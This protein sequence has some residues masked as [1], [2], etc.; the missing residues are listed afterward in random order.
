MR[1]AL[2]PCN[3]HPSAE[4]LGTDASTD[5]E[6]GADLRRI[7]FVATALLAASVVLA[8]TARALEQRYWGLSYIAAWAEAATVGGLADWYAIVALF[9]HPLGV[10]MPHTAIIASNRTRIAESF[11]VFV[12]DQF[13]KPEPIA[14]KLHSVDFAALAADW[15]SDDRRSA[16]LSRFGLRLLPQ[17]LA[18]IEETGLRNFVGDRVMEQM[19]ALDLAPLAARILAAFIEDQRHQKLFDQVL[20]GL[21]RLLDDERL[22]E[23]IREKIRLELPMTFSLVRADAYLVRRFVALVSAAIDEARD[24]PEHPFRRDFDRFARD[25]VEKLG[26][27]PE[28]AER[29]NR[30][31]EDFLSRPEVADLA[32]GLWKSVVAFV[33]NDARSGNSIVERHLARFLNEVGL[34]LA[35][36]PLI[37]TELNVG[38]EKVLQTFIQTNKQ[39]IARFITDQINA[40]DVEAMIWIIELNVGRDLQFIRLNGTFVGGLAGLILYTAERA[41]QIKF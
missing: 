1:W 35:Q 30:L 14:E 26:S 24:N 6:K 19:R 9:R 40:W 36:E 13:L 34:R 8:V 29:A 18:A 2:S 20:A 7:K 39:G 21:R 15:I 12:R 33:Q 38:V 4:S 11:G 5:A 10:P 28:Y 27:S 23:A 3:A 41:L 16:A 32:E 31:K 17:A 37:R 25:F 22:L